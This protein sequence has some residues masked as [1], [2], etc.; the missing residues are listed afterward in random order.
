MNALG[1]GCEANYAH[2]IA[3]LTQCAYWGDIPSMNYLSFIYSLQG[4]EKKA[5]LWKEIV[6]LCQEYLRRG[7]TVIPATEAKTHSTEAVEVYACISS[8]LQDIVYGL[9]HP[10]INFSFVEAVTTPS[11]T[12]YDRMSIINSYE[13]KTWKEVTNSSKKPRKSIGF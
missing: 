7:V 13:Q 8:I 1:I 12:F 6:S 4:D 9:N 10:T 11:L 2:A 3:R 5:K